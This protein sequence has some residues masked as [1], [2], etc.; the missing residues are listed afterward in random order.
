MMR[1]RV[2]VC[3]IASVNEAKVAIR[4][5]ADA[6]GLVAKMPSGPGPIADELIAEI[7]SSI[8]S[9]VDSFLLTS[10]T[11]SESVVDH[12][13]LCGTSVVQLV[14]EVP[15]ET[16]AALRKSCPGVRIVQVIHVQDDRAIGQA[17]GM[18]S[19]VDAVLLDSGRPDA[20][21]PELGGT[22]RQHDWSVSARVVR[23]AGVPVF[24]AGGLNVGNVR[25][26]IEQVAPYGVDLCSGVRTAGK[27]DEEILRD[28][29]AEVGEADRTERQ[30]NQRVPSDAR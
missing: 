7:A 2:K 19:L 21:V 30:P 8:P 18:A 16:Y 15:Y 29:M 14:D 22:G 4:A 1:T 5:G 24:L 28:F 23:E 13:R 27:L 9:G 3:C 6:I 12:V 11:E 20:K 26:A 25:A 10:K 17:R